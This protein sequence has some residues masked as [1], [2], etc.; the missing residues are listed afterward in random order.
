MVEDQTFCISVHYQC[1]KEED[2]FP[3][4][5]TPGHVSLA[6]TMNIASCSNRLCKPMPNKSPVRIPLSLHPETKSLQWRNQLRKLL[7]NSCSII[8]HS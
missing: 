2:I 8:G 5:S 3:S 4:C 6:K 1:V 7:K